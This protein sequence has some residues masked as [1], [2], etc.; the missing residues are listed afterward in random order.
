MTFTTA[1]QDLLT[2]WDTLSAHLE[3]VTAS[4]P[5]YEIITL[6]PPFPD[7]DT[8]TPVGIVEKPIPPITRT[9]TETDG[10]IPSDIDYSEVPENE[11]RPLPD[12]LATLVNTVFTHAEK[13]VTITSEDTDS[14]TI[15]SNQITLTEDNA[16]VTMSIEKDV[17]P[18]TGFHAAFQD[19]IET[20]GYVD[21][22]SIISAASHVAP[23]YVDDSQNPELTMA[24]T[25]YK[26]VPD[27]HTYWSD[28]ETLDD[29]IDMCVDNN[30]DVT[31]EELEAQD[32]YAI[33]FHPVTEYKSSLSDTEIQ[34]LQDWR[35]TV[36]QHVT[37]HITFDVDPVFEYYSDV[38]FR[39]DGHGTIT[40][41]VGIGDDSLPDY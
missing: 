26:Q 36:E 30:D 39:E 21:D 4:D 11:P 1:K 19:V 14:F 2:E 23:T 24:A 16:C 6:S 15:T 35:E 7:S 29:Y 10:E 20:L 38:S 5:P 18:E 40:V 41:R 17:P 12:S 28:C 9:Y 31:R 37:P 3:P 8:T 34:C 32:T 27:P 33:H 22:G 25:V 13:Q